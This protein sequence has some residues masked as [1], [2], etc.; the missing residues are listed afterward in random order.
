ADDALRLSVPLRV[1]NWVGGDRDGNPYVTPDTTIAAA[2]RASHII[3]GRYRQRVDELVERLSLAA[4]IAP[5][6]EALLA[7]LETD[8]AVLPAVW[9]A[10][11]RRNA[12]E[13]MRLKLSFIAARLDATR[14]L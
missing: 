3:L 7:S 13:P 10:N 8:R 9:E 4:H 6:P 5:A 14:R 2:R 1:G 12:D 11:R